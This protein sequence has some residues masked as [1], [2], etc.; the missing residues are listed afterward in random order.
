MKNKGGDI[1]MEKE[2]FSCDIVQNVK[3]KK[4]SGIEIGQQKN[5]YNRARATDCTH[6]RIQNA[7]THILEYYVMAYFFG[8]KV[9]SFLAF[10]SSWFE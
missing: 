6:C 8:Y 2:G 4:K 5:K 7:H 10:D 1:K 9:S 3:T